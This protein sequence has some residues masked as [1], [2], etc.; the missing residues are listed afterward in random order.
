VYTARITY[1]DGDTVTVGT[2]SAKVPTVTSFNSAV[3]AVLADTAL[4][5]AMGAVAASHAG[6]DDTFSTTRSATTRTGRSIPSR[7]AGARSRF[8][9]LLGRRDQDLG[10]RRAGPGLSGENPISPTSPRSS[11]SLPL[12]QP[13][14]HMPGSNVAG[15]LVIG[16]VIGGRSPFFYCCHGSVHHAGFPEVDN[17]IDREPGGDPIINW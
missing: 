8:R 14:L 9:V 5:A 11:G 15:F 12:F 6:D 7:S 13:K 3:T 1:L 17:L 2:V 4:Q 16:A 10:G